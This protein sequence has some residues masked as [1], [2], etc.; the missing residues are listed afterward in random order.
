MKN[1]IDLQDLYLQSP[2]IIKRVLANV[3]AIRRNRY[4]KFGPYKKL[5]AEAINK[6]IISNSIDQTVLLEK[7]NILVNCA[8]QK[9]LYDSN[10][11]PKVI[12]SLKDFHS[13]PILN[14]TT[15]KQYGDIFKSRSYKNLY[16]GRTSGSTGTP[17]TF[18]VDRNSIRASRLY[19]EAFLNKIG[20]VTT[21]RSV[22]FS[23]VKV[24]PFSKLNPPFWVY[25][26]YYRQLQCSSFHIMESTVPYYIDAMKKY[27]V[28]YGTGYPTAWLFLAQLIDKLGIKPPNLKAIVTDSEGISGIEQKYIE[29]IFNCNV[30]QTYGLGEVNMF[31]VMCREG[32]YHIFE[33][34]VYVEIVNENNQPVSPGIEGNIIVTDLNSHGFPIIRYNTGDIGS[35]GTSICQCGLRTKYLEKV[36][37]RV[38]DYIIT[39]DGRKLGRLSHIMKPAKGVLISQIVQIDKDNIEIRIVP[40]KGFEEKSMDIV[41]RNAKNYIGDINIS[42]TTKHDLERTQNGKVRYVIRKFD[43]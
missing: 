17:L 18:F 12:H 38:D 7:L 40:D 36:V 25:I 41:I 28:T 15:Y 1:L 26:D 19:Y 9:G 3:E 21:D 5:L 33:D 35:I 27:K 13:I 10:K 20:C 42:Y 39:K 30:Y 43:N 14:K 37:G 11:I 29:K 16:K 2:P 22:R 31:S 23:G 4:R 6:D 32:H 24:T 34:N 8:Y